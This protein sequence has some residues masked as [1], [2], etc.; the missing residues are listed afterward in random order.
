MASAILD[1]ENA[2]MPDIVTS[3]E[4]YIEIALE[5]VALYDKE[6]SLSW[7]QVRQRQF[8]HFLIPT[9][10]PNIPLAAVIR[11]I[12]R[13]RDHEDIVVAFQYEMN[14]ESP[15]RQP[16]AHRIQDPAA[17]ELFGQF[18]TTIPLLRRGTDKPFWWPVTETREATNP[19]A[20]RSTHWQPETHL[21][22]D[23]REHIDG[24]LFGQFNDEAYPAGVAADPVAV[25]VGLI[26]WE[27]SI[28][29]LALLGQILREE[30]FEDLS[31]LMAGLK[32]SMAVE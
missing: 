4:R 15:E 1:S 24:M 32:E 14:G 23:C 31:F 16:P 25:L 13:L 3:Y 5:D 12:E 20:L 7:K 10:H 19:S 17:L 29:L 22:N 27:S 28:D 18:T 11:F 26:D 2:G 8:V 30:G 21:G 6:M 9:I